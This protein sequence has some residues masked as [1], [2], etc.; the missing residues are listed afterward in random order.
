MNDRFD[1]DVAQVIGVFSAPE[2]I[3]IEGRIRELENR[4]RR[5]DLSRIHFEESGI[6][7]S[8]DERKDNRGRGSDRPVIDDGIASDGDDLGAGSAEDRLPLGPD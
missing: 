3:G 7:R 6:H 4:V 8:I 2:T 5:R 1:P